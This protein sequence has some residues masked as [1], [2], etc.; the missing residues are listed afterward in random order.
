MNRVALMG[1]G[2]M[3]ALHARNIAASRRLELAAVVD[4]KPEAAARIAAITGATVASAEQVLS[5]PTISGVVI[6]S[7]T[8]AHLDDSLNC[9]VAGKAVFC[10][11]P[12]SLSAAAL[13]D[14]RGALSDPGLP[15]LF[16]AFNRRFDPHFAALEARLAAGEIGRLE[17]LHIVNHDPAGPALDFIPRSGGLFRDFTIHD[18]DL[19]AWLIGRPFVEL[20]AFASC[21]VDS[22]IA[23]LGDVDTAKLVMRSADGTLCT[24]S[25]SRRTGYG[26]DQRVEAFGARGALRVENIRSDGVARWTEGGAAESAFPYG[27]ADRY[28]ESYLRELDHFADLLEGSAAPMTGFEASLAAIRLAD[29][30]AQSIESGAAVSLDEG[31]LGHA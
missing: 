18:F 26:Y 12:L 17:S 19:A 11:K 20:F 21:L 23:E 25:N 27:F 8:D 14:A 15:A 29:A 7:S 9:L 16:V 13:E 24:I 2:R 1:A 6:A 31:A 30:A 10:E 3:G 5:D 22:A 28:A 4:P